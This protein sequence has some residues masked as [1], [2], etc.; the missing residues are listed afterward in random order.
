MNDNCRDFHSMLAH[1]CWHKEHTCTQI[2]MYSLSVYREKCGTYFLTNE[3]LVKHVWAISFIFLYMKRDIF[4]TVECSTVKVLTPRKILSIIH[5]LLYW[6][7]NMIYMCVL[8]SAC[9]CGSVCIC[10][11]LYAFVSRCMCVHLNMYLHEG[12]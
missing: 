9:V 7:Y 5:V 11:C 4:K 6:K 1:A 2:F 12:S 3:Y 10:E 8:A